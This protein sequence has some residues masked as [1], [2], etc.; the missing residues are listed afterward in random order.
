MK[1]TE[2]L[3]LIEKEIDPKTST[4]SMLNIFQLGT[5]LK[6]MEDRLWFLDNAGAQKCNDLQHLLLGE[7][8]KKEEIK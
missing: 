2:F 1:I 8:P 7:E 5:M 4:S 3:A 6:C